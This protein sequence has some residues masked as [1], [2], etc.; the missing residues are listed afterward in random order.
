MSKFLTSVREHIPTT[1]P[2][3]PNPKPHVRKLYIQS[4]N[5]GKS[6]L[7]QLFPLEICC[8]CCCHS[9][10]VVSTAVLPLV[11]I[12]AWCNVLNLALFLFM[13]WCALLH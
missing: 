10:I 3:D 1:Q 11:F 9:I 5:N 6:N 8:C 7:L 13:E 12:I 4:N 2:P